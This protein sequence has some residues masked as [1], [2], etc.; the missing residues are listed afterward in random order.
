M[1]QQ[2]TSYPDRPC[3]ATRTGRIFNGYPPPADFQTVTLCVLH[4]GTGVPGVGTGV[5][6]IGTDSPGFG[7]GVPGIGTG[8]PDSGTDSP[9]F[10]AGVPDTGT[11]VPDTGT[12]AA[13]NFN[14]SEKTQT[15]N[16][17]Q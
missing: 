13:D 15:I 1:L 2:Q 4:I 11:G 3:A 5:P 8:V 7:A 10:S 9:G 6:G 16:N 12:D 17:D 14:D